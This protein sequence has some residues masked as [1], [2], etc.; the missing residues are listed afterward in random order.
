MAGHGARAF[1]L[2][3]VAVRDLLPAPGPYGPLAE[4]MRLDYGS[5]LRDQLLVKLDRATMRAALEARSPYLDAGLTEFAL[6]LDPAL[7]VR[8]LRTKWLLKAVARRWL[9]RGIVHRRKRGFSVPLAGWLRGALRPALERLLAPERLRRQGLV[10]EVYVRRMLAEHAG[11]QADH[12]R[13]LWTLIVLQRWLER[14]AP[15]AA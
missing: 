1:A 9:P 15:E 10:S 8:G 4:A 6:R 2:P 5:S 12:A 7:K 11:G 13:A 14:W 3:P